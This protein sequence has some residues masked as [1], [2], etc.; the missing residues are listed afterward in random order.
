MIVVDEKQGSV[1]EIQTALH[2]C[3]ADSYRRFAVD[4]F[5]VTENALHEALSKRSP[6]LRMVARE[7]KVLYMKNAKSDWLRQAKEEMA[8]AHDLC[9]LG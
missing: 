5:V 9:R 8:T 4:P 3:L 1:S 6:F 7:G 2:H